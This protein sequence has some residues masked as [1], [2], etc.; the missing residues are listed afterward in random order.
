MDLLQ[1]HLIVINVVE[2]S[3]NQA[4]MH[5]QLQAWSQG[6]LAQ[7]IDIQILYKGCYHIEFY[8]GDKVAKL[9][10]LG[11]VKMKGI[12]IQCLKWYARC[13]LDDLRET[14]ARKLLFSVMFP[15]L[16]K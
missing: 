3:S 10:L 5:H 2:G 1:Q 15:T 7:I 8:C 14:I 9:L 16:P 6:E 12:W 4:K 11:S 13:D